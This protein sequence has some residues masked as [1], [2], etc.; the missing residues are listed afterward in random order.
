MRGQ[1]QASAALPPIRDLIFTTAGYVVATASL[2]G[3]CEEKIPYFHRKS[4]TEKQPRN[5]NNF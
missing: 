4:N 2:D 5:K 3:F 1:R